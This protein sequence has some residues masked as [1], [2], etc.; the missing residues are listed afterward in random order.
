LS[1]L[2][3]FDLLVFDFDGTLAN[4]ASWFRSILPDLSQRFGFRCPDED[5][6]EV[7]RHKPPR[8]CAHTRR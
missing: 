1:T 6:L 4:S 5:E 7:L 2:R 8:A 3:D